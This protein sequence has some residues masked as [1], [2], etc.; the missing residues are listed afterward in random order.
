MVDLAAQGMSILMVSSELPQI[1]AGRIDISVGSQ[2]ATA[3]VL[4][5]RISTSST[6]DP[7]KRVMKEEQ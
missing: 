3:A 7:R 6:F 4:R 1:L 2:F 5:G